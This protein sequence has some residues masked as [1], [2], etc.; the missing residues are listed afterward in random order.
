[1]LTTPILSNPRVS[2]VVC[3]AAISL[4]LASCGSTRTTQSTA[5]APKTQNTP[6]APASLSP[7]EQ[8]A[9]LARAEQST[10]IQI[11][12][13]S[14]P[15]GI[16]PVMVTPLPND[17]IAPSTK[18][19]RPLPQSLDEIE[20]SWVTLTQPLRP[21]PSDAARAD[22]LAAY[23][24]SR[25]MLLNL[26][27]A[28]AIP[29]LQ[30]ATRLDPASTQPWRELGVANLSLNRRAAGV[31]AL[32]KAFELGD[33]SPF[34]C[35]ILGRESLRSAKSGEGLS[36]LTHGF[37]NSARADDPALP[38]LI[39]AELGDALQSDG[40]LRAARDA[41]ATALDLPETWG[42]ESRLRTELAELYRRRFDLWLRV[43]D[44]SCQLADHA[45]AFEAYERAASTPSLDPGAVLPRRV[46]AAMRTGRPAQAATLVLDSIERADGRFDDRHAEL[47]GYLASTPT[48]APVLAPALSNIRATQAQRLSPSMRARLDRITAAAQPTN[49]ARASLL[50]SAVQNPSDTDA[51]VALIESFEGDSTALAPALISLAEASPSDAASVAH[52]LLCVGRNVD[53]TLAALSPRAGI[54]PRLIE[55]AILTRTGRLKEA[56]SRLD[57][58][59]DSILV[60][61]LRAAWLAQRITIAA[62]LADA[63][64]VDRL[65][66]QLTTLASEQLSPARQV[67]LAS[68][69]ME[70]RRFEESAAAINALPPTDVTPRAAL[71][72]ADASLRAGNAQSAEQFLKLALERDPTSEPA[73]EALA[74]LYS[75]SGALPN[76]QKL[77]EL[78]RKL[79]QSVPSGRLLRQLTAR[80]M[81]ARGAF[82]DAEPILIEIARQSPADQRSVEALSHL[83]ARA[84]ATDAM[85]ANR[86]GTFLRELAVKRPDSP[87]I[88]IASSRALAAN[89][90]P[91]AGLESINTRVSYWPMP[92]LERV[93]EQIIREVMNDA[94][95]AD[96]LARQRLEAAPRTFA[97]AAELAEILARAGRLEDAARVLG[98]A[99]AAGARLSPEQSK[100]IITLL[101]QLPQD[102]ADEASARGT[103]SLFDQLQ[104]Q[105]VTF[106]SPLLVKRLR[107]AAFALDPARV[108][109]LATAAGKATPELADTSF[110]LVIQYYATS[111]KYDRLLRFVEEVATRAEPWKA[112][113][114]RVWLTAI[115]AWGSVDDARRLIAATSVPEKLKQFT[116]LF[117]TT[118]S[119]DTENNSPNRDQRAEIAYWLAGMMVNSNRD[120]QAIPVYRLALE[121]QPDYSIVANDLGYLLLERNESLDEAARLIEAAHKSLNENPNV[122]D[123]MGWLRYK[124]GVFNDVVDGAGTITQEGAVTLLTRAIRLSEPGIPNDAG[125]EHL[126][127]AQWRAGLTTDALKTWRQAATAREG[128]IQFYRGLDGESARATELKADLDKLKGKIDAGA[129]GGQPAVAPIWPTTNTP[130]P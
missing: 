97:N 68:A 69:L 74:A 113:Y 87:A 65:L 99:L 39:T 108:F 58:V 5:E 96:E 63:A 4:I 34:I 46:F 12:T 117:D 76:E 120:E 109:E 23:A 27:T 127:D 77:T 75:T 59:A 2:G 36:L 18:L 122:I 54:A 101:G 61:E 93:R 11:P 15:P 114:T 50:E 24:R 112:D 20:S 91:D 83:V 14:P 84:A 115:G 19:G 6:P 49:E 40:R 37:K 86:V 78:A 67:P 52:A 106:T 29:L 105:N 25:L 92:D 130:A 128:T 81:I 55:S 116:D 47:I 124:Q 110:D 100:V 31:A 48:L 107:Y 94:P 26:D 16:D 21:V 90:K 103:L 30:D 13:L 28:K 85:L 66:P 60:P 102:P 98:E 57:K 126:G 82:R 121:L 43:G 32:R 41:F 35:Y 88:L 104:A 44:L 62:E 1:M 3:C 72:A 80:D 56:A 53:E 17:Q 8:L 111:T 33:D 119:L 42:T 73:F 10:P 89:G 70:T 38:F 22:A 118:L 9:A 51:I 71:L 64:T 7:R 45:I 123:S 95:R 79:R 125:L 129:A